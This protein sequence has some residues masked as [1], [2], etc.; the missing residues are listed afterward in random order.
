VVPFRFGRRLANVVAAASLF[1]LAILLTPQLD[2]FGQVE[3]A[4]K[5]ESQQQEIEA[6]RSAA[7]TRADRLK[8]E[9]ERAAEEADEIDSQI[10]KLK[11]DFRRMQPKTMKANS[12]VLD[13]HSRDLNDKW[14]ST[15]GDGQV[16]RMMNEPISQKQI[17]SSRSQKMNEWLKEL[18]EGK[19]ESLQ[20]QMQK[21]QDTMR[22]MMEAKSPEER[23]QLASQLQQ[24]LQ[25][26]NKFA[27]D[28]A[29]SKELSSALSKAMTALQASR[30]PGENAEQMQLSAEALEA[31]KES[32]QLSELEM[33]RIAQSARDLK[34]L[35][36]AL[37]TLQQ[38][39]QLNQQQQLDGSKCEGCKSMKDYAELYARMSGQGA[40]GGDKD[41]NEG[42]RGGTGRGG[43]TPEDDSD[44]EGYKKEKERPQIQAGKILLSIKTKEYADEK[45]FDPE[46]MRQYQES[47]SAIKSGV[48]SAID[49]EEIPP[50]YVD[51]IKGYFDRIEKIDSKPGVKE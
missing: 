1:G 11:S 19:T 39:Q 26:L 41:R 45:D 35:E 51:G 17:G 13:S 15:A 7:L 20:K 9:A 36:D 48:Q 49:S 16:W 18:Q 6:I 24:E 4:K 47:L 42:G 10:G 32:L 23:K 2:P 43:E 40:G 22:A 37:K 12:K 21:A 14:K 28:K 44:P 50:G 30:T 25:D 46:K 27:K 34:K 8:K 33:E 38:A 3:A 5:V 31:L 29:G